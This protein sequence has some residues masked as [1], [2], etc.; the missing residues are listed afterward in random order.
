MNGLVRNTNG[1]NVE[2]FHLEKLSFFPLLWNQSKS[3][4]KTK[5]KKNKKSI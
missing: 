4:S 2:K 5:T 1:V 3:Q